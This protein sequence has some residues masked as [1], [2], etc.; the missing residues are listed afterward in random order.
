MFEKEKTMSKVIRSVYYAKIGEPCQYAQ[1]TGSAANSVLG[2]DIEKAVCEMAID[3][4]GRGQYSVSDHLRKRG[5]EISPAGVR[6]IWLRHGLETCRKR[7]AALPSY[8]PDYRTYAE[9]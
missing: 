2:P 8:Q 1:A 4:P 7:L 5:V 3:N 9:A 6:N